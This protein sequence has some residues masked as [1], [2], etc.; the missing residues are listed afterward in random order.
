MESKRRILRE[1]VLL[2]SKLPQPTIF[3]KENEFFQCSTTKW[4]A[5]E[6]VKAIRESP[7]DP[8]VTLSI[9]IDKMNHCSLTA[10]NKKTAL[11]FSIAY[12]TAVWI[13]SIVF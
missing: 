6:I 11:M 4:A 3:M 5:T 12:D 2:I 10:R 9:F 13:E 8:Q 7:E 1:I